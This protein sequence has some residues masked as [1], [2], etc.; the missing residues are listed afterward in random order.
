M[1]NL[2]KRLGK[3]KTVMGLSVYQKQSYRV[4]RSKPLVPIGYI[5]LIFL[6]VSSF[7][8]NP[9]RYLGYKDKSSEHTDWN[10]CTLVYIDL[11][12]ERFHSS[13][14]RQYDMEHRDQPLCW[15][16]ARLWENQCL[17]YHFPCFNYN[18]NFL[19][20]W[21]RSNKNRSCLFIVNTTP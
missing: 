5:F 6:V 8:P 14:V 10:L 21:C 19:F 13:K 11:S 1:F 15:G 4:S 9:E 18:S 12:K 16:L 2:H 7:N 3:S 20:G 17:S